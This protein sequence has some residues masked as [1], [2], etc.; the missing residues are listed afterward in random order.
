MKV[1]SS[2]GCLLALVTASSGFSVN[3]HKTAL[4]NAKS[5]VTS[6]TSIHN[7]RDP[8][9]VFPTTFAPPSP[10]DNN[11]ATGHSQTTTT[12]IHNDVENGEIKTFSHAPLSYFDIVNLRSKGPRKGADVGV[13]HDA[14]RP[15]SSDG[16]LSAGSWWCAAGGWPS[17]NL[18]TTTEVF[19]VLEGYGC[20]TDLDGTENYFGPGDTVILP[21]GWSGRWDVLQ[22]IHKVW[23]VTD[24]PDVA[25]CTKAM[26]IPYHRLSPQHLVSSGVRSDAT[27]GTPC[28][29]HAIYLENG[30]MEVG[31]WTCTPGSF[32]VSER[33]TSEAFFVLEGLFFLTNERDGTAMRCKAGD[34]VILP[35]GWSG[36]WDIIEPVKKLWVSVN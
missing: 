14:T 30:Y 22:D 4:T 27:H 10:I 9:P 25:M 31:A 1:L 28:T 29:A 3:V 8:N 20:L 2:Y 35:K 23:A 7:S 36:H 13:P 18:R 16:P 33:S 32:P 19:Y 15:L 24:H 26:V 34:T 21:K 12:T 11:G 5:T 17:P 6:S